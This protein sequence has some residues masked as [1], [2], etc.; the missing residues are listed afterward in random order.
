M[1]AALKPDDRRALVLLAEHRLSVAGAD[2]H[3]A[4]RAPRVARRSTTAPK[5]RPFV[6]AI[7]FSCMSYLGIAISLCPMI[8]PNKYTLWQAA[9]SNRR[10][11][12][13]WSGT[14]FLLPVIL[15]YTGWSYWVFRGKVRADIGY[16]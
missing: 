8:V 2:R 1:D 9:S 7:G 3:R 15:M 12:S 4:D 6:G 10:R 13:C 5:P 14:L 11:L 16:H